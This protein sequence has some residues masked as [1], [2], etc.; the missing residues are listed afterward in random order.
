MSE[1]PFMMTEEILMEMTQTGID[2]Q[3]CHERIRK[4]SVAAGEQVKQLG[5]SNDLVERWVG[6]KFLILFRHS[7][8]HIKLFS[9]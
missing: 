5:K 8:S 1:M 3:E 4:H 9:I 6:V 2:R 7:F